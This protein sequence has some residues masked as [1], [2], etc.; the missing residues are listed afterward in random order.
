MMDKVHGVVGLADQ[1]IQMVHRIASELR[2]GI[3]DDLGLAAAIE[4][5]GGDFSRRN[6]I[7]CRV[8][9]TIAEPRIS[10]RNATALFR[11]VQEALTNV[12]HHAHASR[13]SVELWEEDQTLLI[14]VQDDGIGISDEQCA[15]P[16]AFGLIGIRE[17]VQGLRGDVLILGKPDKG[18]TLLVTIPVPLE[19][20]AT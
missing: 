13:A 17:R 18:T 6:G 20:S 19:G 9:I 12:A 16:T 15:S 8:D 14:R 10:G 2:P 3:L 11:I 5:L 7:P 1:T 4:W